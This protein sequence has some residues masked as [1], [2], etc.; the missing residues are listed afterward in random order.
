MRALY[1]QLV[2]LLVLGGYIREYI[3]LY[4]DNGKE[5][6]N[7]YNRLCGDYQRVLLVVLI[8]RSIR[9]IRVFRVSGFRVFTG[10]GLVLGLGLRASVL[11]ATYSL[12]C[13]LG[14]G[15]FMVYTPQLLTY[16]CWPLLPR[17]ISPQQQ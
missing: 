12:S 8:I 14:E 1:Y 3:G 9:I 13:R 5:N 10:L 4:W 15:S 17:T 7:H 6:G 11:A 2:L 16:F